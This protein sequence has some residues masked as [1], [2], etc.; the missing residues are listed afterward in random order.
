[1]STVSLLR[2]FT[3]EPLALA[4]REDSWEEFAVEVITS[5]FKSHTM[6]VTLGF[7]LDEWMEGVPQIVTADP[8]S[9]PVFDQVDDADW[10]I[11]RLDV[12]GRRH[13]FVPKHPGLL[14]MPKFQV[15]ERACHTSPPEV[16]I[17]PSDCPA[18]VL[19]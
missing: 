8:Q 7:E 12:R 1:M 15:G 19:L 5:P 18:F 16:R 10:T 9:F 2:E 14:R 4:F 6:A 13:L 11:C 17:L 3:T